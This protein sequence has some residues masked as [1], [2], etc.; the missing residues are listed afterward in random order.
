MRNEAHAEEYRIYGN[1]P[2][3]RRERGFAANMM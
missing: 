2:E 3:I 1:S